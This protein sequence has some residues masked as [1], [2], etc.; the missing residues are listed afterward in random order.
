[1]KK[2]SVLSICFLLLFTACSKNSDKLLYGL[3]M[4]GCELVRENDTHGIHGDGILILEYDCQSQHMRIEN[5]VSAWQPLPLTD[6]LQ[7]LM[8]GGEKDNIIYSYNI[9]KEYQIPTIENG[10]YLFIDRT[11]PHT[12]F[13]E[14]SVLLSQQS[15]NFTLLLYDKELKKLYFIEYDT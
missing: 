14:E 3:D 9:A 15:L 11:D 1:M 13:D 2:L 6:T 5:V 12:N 7:L 8:Y 10:F 4:T